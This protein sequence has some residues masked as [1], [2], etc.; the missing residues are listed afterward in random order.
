MQRLWEAVALHGD[1][2]FKLV[3]KLLV[4][5]LGP[6]PLS[7]FGGCAGELDTECTA[8]RT[9][10]K[11]QLEKTMMPFS[12]LSHHSSPE[13]DG[14]CSFTPSHQISHQ[15]LLRITSKGGF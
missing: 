10:S 6:L 4:S 9:N 12:C 1:D 7:R 13:D 2:A 14:G 5:D 3:G 8:V 11:N 15:F